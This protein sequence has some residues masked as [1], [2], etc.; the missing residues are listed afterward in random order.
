M[1]DILAD[2]LKSAGRIEQKVDDLSIQFKDKAQ[3]HEVRLRRLEKLSSKIVGVL[4]IVIA[5]LTY[6]YHK[7]VKRDL[8]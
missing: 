4:T 2:L 6:L 1:D 7:W 3:N 5:P 8:A